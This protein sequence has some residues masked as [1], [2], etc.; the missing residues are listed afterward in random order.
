MRKYF[1]TIA[2]L[3]SV[4]LLFTA[5]DSTPSVPKSFQQESRLPNI[6]PD[7]TDITIPCNIAPMNFAVKEGT[8]TVVARFT[9]PAGEFTYGKG[10]K[11]IIDADEWTEML[12]ASK[13]KDIKVEVFAE[14]DGKWKGFKAFNI[15]VAEEPIDEY[16]SYRLIQPSYV[17]YEKLVIAQRNMTNFEEKDIYNNMLVSTEKDGQCINCHSYQNYKT[18]FSV[19]ALPRKTTSALVGMPLVPSNTCSVTSSPLIFTTC[20]SL[21]SMVASS[22]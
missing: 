2:I 12:E 8:E 10:Q 3:I 17:A 20:A 19:G 5:C 13:G 1:S 18:T 14:K 7:Y 11:V 21:P 9:S 16:I 6:M 4:Q 15:H 22:S